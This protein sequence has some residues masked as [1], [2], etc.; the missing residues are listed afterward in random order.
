ME[1]AASLAVA[2]VARRVGPARWSVAVGDRVI[3][4]EPATDGILALERALGAALGI[5]PA[6]PPDPPRFAVDERVHAHGGLFELEEDTI[7]TVV[8]LP[9]GRPLWEF[10]G[11][12]SH[13]YDGVGW[14]EATGGSGFDDVVLGA[15]GRKV[16]ARTGDEVKAWRLD[17]PAAHRGETA[18]S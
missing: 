2:W 3:E 9:E 13:D 16:L 18:L 14:S 6:A 17:A 15:D 8:A 12:S 5:A 10:R 1:V 7:W 11:S 4:V